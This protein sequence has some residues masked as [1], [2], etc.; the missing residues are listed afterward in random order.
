MKNL[1]PPTQKFCRKGNHM[2][3]VDK[4]YKHPHGDGKFNICVECA[5]Q[6]TKDNKRKLKEGTIKAF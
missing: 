4:F 3:D 5:K 1:I 6:R 2:V